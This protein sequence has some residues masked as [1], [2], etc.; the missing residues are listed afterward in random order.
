MSSFNDGEPKAELPTKSDG[1]LS[2]YKVRKKKKH[3]SIKGS[4]D[5]S[6]PEEPLELA[7]SLISGH[8]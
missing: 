7:V 8:T 4:S 6:N 1:H 2:H 5:Q 3:K